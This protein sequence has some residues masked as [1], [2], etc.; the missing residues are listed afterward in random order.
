MNYTLEMVI[1][2]MIY[3]QHLMTARLGI[4][5]KAITLTV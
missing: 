1:G 4:Q 3:I 5:P 2:R